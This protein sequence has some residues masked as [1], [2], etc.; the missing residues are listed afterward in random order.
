MC[1]CINNLKA[2][3][4]LTV[5]YLICFFLLRKCTRVKRMYER[6]FLIVISQLLFIRDNKVLSE[7]LIGE[8]NSSAKKLDSSRAICPVVVTISCLTM[9]ARSHYEEQLLRSLTSSDMSRPRREDEELVSPVACS[10][11]QKSDQNGP[12]STRCA[13]N[14]EARHRVRRSRSRPRESLRRS[15]AY[16]P[17]EQL[18]RSNKYKRKRT[19]RGEAR[20]RGRPEVADEEPREGRGR[21][22]AEGRC[23]A[24]GVGGG[25]GESETK[26]V[27]H[28]CESY[29]PVTWSYVRSRSRT[30]LSWCVCVYAC[31]THS[32][33]RTACVCI[34]MCVSIS[35]A[36]LVAKKA[37]ERTRDWSW[38]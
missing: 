11:R 30:Y 32:S 9:R 37:K 2:F 4:S 1:V 19:S 35:R 22:N 16:L 25:R 27:A 13:S 24:G 29:G 3:L 21:E 8:L 18:R 5:G 31:I 26:R 36:S 6:H 7:L 34:C 33:I 12:R 10:R 14:K 28:V 17:R 23:V 15:C 38:V 20:V